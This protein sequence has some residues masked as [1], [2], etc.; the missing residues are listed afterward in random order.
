MMQP[1]PMAVKSQTVRALRSL[2]S[3]TS[4]S[5]SK[6]LSGFV[7][8]SLLA[9]GFLSFELKIAYNTDAGIGKMGDF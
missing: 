2:C 9:M 8:K 1:M 4:V 7:L 3:S 6:R 5:A